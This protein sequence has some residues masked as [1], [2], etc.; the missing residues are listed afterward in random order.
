MPT[1]SESL[2]IAI[3][4]ALIADPAVSAIVGNRVHDGR[5]TAYPAITFGPFDYVPEEFDC[6]DG[7]TATLQLDCWVRDEGKRLR[8]AKALADTV[9]ALLDD[10]ELDLGTHA[11]TRLSVDSVRAFMD[12]DGLTG[13]GIVT[14]AAE[15]EAR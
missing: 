13:H 6:I 2:Q 14:L 8:P 11:L 1:P 15:I 7:R 5:P 3:Y 9:V 10:A 4:E 12:S